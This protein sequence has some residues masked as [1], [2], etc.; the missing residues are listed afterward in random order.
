MP[1]HPFLLVC[2]V[3]GTTVFLMYAAK[4]TEM[5][6]A[7]AICLY[8]DGGF[9]DQIDVKIENTN[10]SAPIIMDAHRRGES[11]P[12]VGVPG[13]QGYPERRER[14][15]VPPELATAVWLL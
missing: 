11:V 5:L 9:R 8:C 15:D 7:Q 14:L 2:G 6:E 10:E 13:M 12:K 3:S 4:Y 1:D